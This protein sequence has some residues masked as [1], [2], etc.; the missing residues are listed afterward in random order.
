MKKI[1]HLELKKT[2]AYIIAEI[3]NAAQGVYKDN[4]KLIKVAKEANA[5]AVKF[6]F[7]K[8]DFLA[9]PSYPKYEIYKNT[10]YTL[11]QRTKFIQKSKKTGLDIWVDIFDRWG[12]EVAKENVKNIDVV[13][14]PPTVILDEKLVYEIMKLGLPTA[15]G[16]GGYEDNDIDFVLSKIKKF[17]NQII[18]MYGFQAFPTPIEDATISRIPYLRKKYKY[19][20]GYADHTEGGSEMSFLLPQYAF[21]AGSQIIEKH[22]ILDRS[23]K[24]LDYYSSLEPNE[25]K[26]FV[27]KMKECE[28]IWK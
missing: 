9:A 8:Y 4:L 6:Q 1:K 13:K 18:M 24:G 11:E 3:A 10:F 21:F 14:I 26:L 22:I 28:S 16:V 25:F 2:Q 15:I 17:N 7:Y 20:L 19:P 12:L 5:N 27:K 23:N